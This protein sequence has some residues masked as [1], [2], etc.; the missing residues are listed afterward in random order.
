MTVSASGG[1]FFVFHH[2]L[3]QRFPGMGEVLGVEM[4]RMVAATEARMETCG[5]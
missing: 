3:G 5:T 4:P 2:E 1:I